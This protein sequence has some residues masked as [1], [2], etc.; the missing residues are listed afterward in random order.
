MKKQTETE[1]NDII[2]Y[3]GSLEAYNEEQRRC[4]LVTIET[5]T[6]ANPFIKRI[7]IEHAMPTEKVEVKKVK[8][9]RR[10]FWL[11]FF[12]QKV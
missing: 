6:R 5:A 3:Y 7:K 11:K 10:P 8:P 9:G 1:L 2:R 12:G 4:S